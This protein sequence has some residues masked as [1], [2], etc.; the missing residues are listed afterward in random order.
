MAV[1][2]NRKKKNGN[3]TRKIGRP[4][5]IL[6]NGERKTVLHML[7]AGSSRAE[8]CEALRI[9]HSQLNRAFVED[10]AFQ[11]A[12]KRAR[13]VYDDRVVDALVR[14]A[15]GGN[16]VAMIFWLKNRRPKEWRD[17]R[18]VAIE[19]DENVSSIL[20]KL[21]DAEEKETG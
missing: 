14:E 10:P 12:V 2:K 5:R 9:G 15:F 7:E 11:D 3:G 6:N 8:V 19:A 17:R 1:R 21:A 16:V 4:K 20:S 13:G 18:D